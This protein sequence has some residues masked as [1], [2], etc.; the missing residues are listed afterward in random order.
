[1]ALDKPTYQTGVEALQAELFANAGNLT[2]AQA[3]ARFAEGMANLN[4]AF[5]KTGKPQVP[6]TG[7]VAGATAV[8]GTS[9]TGTII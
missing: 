4:D 9:V 1:M 6:G 7:L 3:A 8:T 2:T 5:V